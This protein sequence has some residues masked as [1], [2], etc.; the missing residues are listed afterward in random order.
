MHRQFCICGREY[1]DGETDCPSCGNY[2]K[3]SFGE[4]FTPLTRKR[5]KK[6]K[7]HEQDCEC[8]VCEAHGTHLREL[9][10]GE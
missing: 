3:I 5:D 2:I 8:S 7:K 6:Q 4:E 9:D 1:E 10:F